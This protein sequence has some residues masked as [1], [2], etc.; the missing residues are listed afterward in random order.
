[1]YVCKP[2]NRV[3]VEL[4]RELAIELFYCGTAECNELQRGRRSDAG[5]AG[6]PLCSRRGLFTEDE[7]GRTRDGMVDP[8]LGRSWWGQVADVVTSRVHLRGGTPY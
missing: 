2:S 8:T 7:S 6:R 3:G 1:M 5:N 4:D